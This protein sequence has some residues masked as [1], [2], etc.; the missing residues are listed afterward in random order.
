[1]QALGFVRISKKQSFVEISFKRI[2]SVKNR[3]GPFVCV[4]D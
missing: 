3:V 2:Q 1:M 4:I